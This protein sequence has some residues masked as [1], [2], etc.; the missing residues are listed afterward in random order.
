[1]YYN[2]KKREEEVKIK[3]EKGGEE[4]KKKRTR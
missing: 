4:K 2:I 1:M 3:P